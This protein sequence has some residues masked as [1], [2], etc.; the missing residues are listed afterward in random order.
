MNRTSSEHAALRSASLLCREDRSLAKLERDRTGHGAAELARQVKD[1]CP[2][3]SKA[4][5]RR[6]ADT[7]LAARLHQASH[8]G[9]MSRTAC[10]RTLAVNPAASRKTPSRALGRIVEPTPSLAHR[11]GEFR[12]ARILEAFD[13]C[14]F[15][16]SRAWDEAGQVHLTFGPA[17]AS[18]S[19]T[20]GWIDY[21]SHGHR[22]GIVGETVR[23]AVP[24]DW[25]VRVRRTGL[26]VL[27]GLLALDAE[28][29][30]T[31]GAV[32]VYRATWARQGRGVSLVTER[33]YIARHTPSG[34]TYHSTDRDPEAALRGLKRKVMAQAI[35]AADRDAAQA[36]RRR[37]Q[38]ERRAAQLA[39]LV[40]QLSR[41]D[42]SEIEHVEITRQDSIRAGN[43][44][45]GTDAFIE[46]FLPGR[47]EGTI[48]E[49]AAAMGRQDLAALAGTDLTL[50]RQLAAACLVAVRR[51]RNARR[52]LAV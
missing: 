18:Q 48:G 35:P 19:T 38:Q 52:M 30:P 36:T 16:H 9:V 6:A 40:G 47:A 1:A 51:D 25:G 21:K 42:L 7:V 34:T 32:E 43:C 29:L 11:L 37:K 3:V 10:S 14:R 24:E 49:L 50:A 15:R 22:R 41:W 28:Q 8:R 45:P 44:E 4:A 23:L 27:D 13:A 31:V 39:R 5:A 20:E 12:R 26:A 33:G 17:T 46:R 2:E